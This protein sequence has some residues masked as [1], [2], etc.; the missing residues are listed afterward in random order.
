MKIYDTVLVKVDLMNHIL[1]LTFSG[2]HAESSHDIAK[3]PFI[4]RVVTVPIKYVKFLS[5]FLFFFIS[6]LINHFDVLLSNFFFQIII[7]VN[8]LI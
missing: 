3:L 6:K 7:S 2:V 1:E 8:G 4:N 5:V